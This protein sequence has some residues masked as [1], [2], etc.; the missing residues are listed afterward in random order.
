MVSSRCSKG[1]LGA[2]RDLCPRGVPEIAEATIGHGR[3]IYP[4]KNGAKSGREIRGFG[5]DFG[6]F[7]GGLTGTREK[8]DD[9]EVKTKGKKVTKEAD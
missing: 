6:K 3:P 9:E 2:Q 8:G 5:K 7:F 1:N 4:L